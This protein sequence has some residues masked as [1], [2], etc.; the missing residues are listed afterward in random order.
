MLCKVEAGQGYLIANKDKN[1]KVGK[2]TLPSGIG[3]C[4]GMEGGSVEEGD[5]AELYCESNWFC[6]FISSGSKLQRSK[7]FGF[8]RA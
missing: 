3:K 5:G 7:S 8:M 6:Y 1:T 2:N 4:C